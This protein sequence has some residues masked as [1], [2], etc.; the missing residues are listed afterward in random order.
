MIDIVARQARLVCVFTLGRK[1]VN[2]CEDLEHGAFH[3]FL[4]A[5]KKSI[6]LDLELPNERQRFI[7]FVPTSADLLIHQFAAAHVRT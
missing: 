3:Q 1:G 7:D 2:N 4:N 5:G 6:T